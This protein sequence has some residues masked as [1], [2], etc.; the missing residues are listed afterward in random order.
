MQAKCG[1]SNEAVQSVTERLA[2]LL[3]D[4]HQLYIKNLAYHW[5][6]EDQR[7]HLLH[8]LFEQGYKELAADMDLVAERI[9]ELGRFAPQTVEELSKRSRLSDTQ[10]ATTGDQMID[11]LAKDYE[12]LLLRLREDI[13]CADGQ[14]D[15]GTA[16]MLT[17]LLRQYEKRVWFLRSHLTPEYSLS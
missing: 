3:S 2:V 8:E 6:V 12:L 11:V 15:I 4:I 10:V 1:L 16:D 13:E 5:N 7:F 9:R 17:G 14:G